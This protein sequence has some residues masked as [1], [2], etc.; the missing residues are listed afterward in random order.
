MPPIRVIPAAY[1]HSRN[2]TGVA[3]P[4]NAT[5]T[6]LV[7]HHE[8]QRAAQP[9]RIDEDEGTFRLANREDIGQIGVCLKTSAVG[10]PARG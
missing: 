6:E 10:Q 2:G 8:P 4:A 9:V 5:V 3:R 1:I 7:P